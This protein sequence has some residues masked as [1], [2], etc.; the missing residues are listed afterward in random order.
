[1]KKFSFVVVALIAL[2]GCGPDA[3]QKKMVADLTTEVS[4]MINDAS[5]SLG[6]MDDIAGQITSAM[7][8]ADSLAMK[9]PKDTASIMGA[10]NQLKSAKDRVMSVKDNVSEWV[11]NYKTPDLASM[12]FDQV[13]SDLKKNKDELTSATSEIQGA[14]DVATTAIDGYKNVAS[15]LMSKVMAKRK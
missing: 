5:S 15:G 3:E 7:S 11:K 4:S 12:K 2:A 9:F 6:K 1:M 14:L 10:I 8:G 13:V